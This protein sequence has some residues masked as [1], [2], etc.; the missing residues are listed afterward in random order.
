MSS[1]YFSLQL[2]VGP[3]DVVVLVLV[4]EHAILCLSKP[5]RFVNL[6]LL[7]NVCVFVS[8]R[9]QIKRQLELIKRNCHGH[10]PAALNILEGH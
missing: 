4:V 3:V 9:S 2:K 8:A 7:A 6:A 1:I 5:A 10:L